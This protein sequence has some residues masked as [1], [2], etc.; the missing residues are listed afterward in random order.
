L[1]GKTDL[2]ISKINDFLGFE[3]NANNKFNIESTLRQLEMYL[4]FVDDANG[5]EFYEYLVE[6]LK[7]VDG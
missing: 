5:R 1:L 2:A 4:H 7:G 3:Y 6:S